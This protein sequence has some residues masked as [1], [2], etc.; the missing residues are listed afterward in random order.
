MSAP[1]DEGYFVKL[2]LDVVF[3][4]V[5]GERQNIRLTKG[6][7]SDLLEIPRDEIQN[8][9]ILNVE[10]PPERWRQ[11]FNRLDLQL[12][13]DDK[14]VNVEMQ[15]RGEKHFR[16]RSLFYWSRIY[17][18]DLK[19]GEKYRNLKQ[20][21]CVNILDFNLFEDEDDYHT[22]VRVTYGKRRRV[23]TKKFAIHVFEL[24]KL[25]RFRKGA[26]K[27]DWLGLINVGSKE[28]L[29]TIIESAVIP[30]VR[31]AGRILLDFQ[32]DERVRQEAWYREKQTHDEASQIDD[33]YEEGRAEGREEGRAEGREEGREEGK[34]EGREEGT[35]QTLA[36]LVARGRLTVSEAAEDAGMSV[37]EFENL[38]KSQTKR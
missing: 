1:W 9:E 8:V 34:E 25:D 31:D 18:R 24:K 7:I 12:Q 5:F 37:E 11:K 19:E 14:I 3:K 32:A 27:E 2:K 33:A 20:T 28:E 22:A 10:I 30:E 4:R 29:M 36:R 13:V 21:I 26:P 6:L 23:F 17:T 35:L 15:V 16:E 38:T